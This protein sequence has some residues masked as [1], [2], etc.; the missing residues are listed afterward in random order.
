MPEMAACILR[1]RLPPRN[2]QA[3]N[4]CFARGSIIN[5]ILDFS[6][7]EAGKLE[8]ETIDFSLRQLVEDVGYMFARAAE[9]KGLEMVCAVPHD[10][11]MELKGDPVRMRQILTNL[12]GNAVKFTSHGEIV[13]RVKLLHESAQQARFRF[14]VQDSGIGIDEAAQ[15]RMFSA[16]S[17]ADTSTTRRYGGSGLGLAIAKRLVEMMQGR[18]GLG[19]HAGPRLGVLVRDSVREAGRPCTHLD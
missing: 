8:I 16:F 2:N 3:C 4:R 18:I 19:K 15:S 13:V 14:E 7:I 11:P 17:Q 1:F 6:K 5:D 9:A 12:V 10:L